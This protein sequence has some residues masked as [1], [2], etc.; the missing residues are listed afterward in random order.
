VQFVKIDSITFLNLN[1]NIL[2]GNVFNMN[3]YSILFRRVKIDNKTK[4][5]FNKPIDLN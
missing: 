5:L 2:L 1:E 4:L 3:P